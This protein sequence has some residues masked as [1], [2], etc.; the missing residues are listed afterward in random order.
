M[1]GVED[2]DM[3]EAGG[4]FGPVYLLDRG[5]WGKSS[6]FKKSCFFNE[7]VLL[8]GGLGGCRD[9][10]YC[11]GVDAFVGAGWSGVSEVR[12]SDGGDEESFADPGE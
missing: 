9:G 7:G 3:G 12:D 6:V 10:A 2:A 1:A 11:D 5:G 4:L 8:M